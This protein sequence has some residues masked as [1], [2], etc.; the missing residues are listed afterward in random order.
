[1]GTGVLDGIEGQ[2]HNNDQQINSSHTHYLSGSTMVMN[3]E[4]KLKVTP[5]KA[6]KDGAGDGLV[7]HSIDEI[8]SDDKSAD[9]GEQP[10]DPFRVRSEKKGQ[11]DIRVRSR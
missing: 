8:S 10:E 9:A 1:M 6:D 7:N 2:H 11:G 3:S 4:D 5:I